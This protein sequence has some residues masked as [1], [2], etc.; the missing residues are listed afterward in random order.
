MKLYKITGGKMKRLILPFMIL[1]ILLLNIQAYASKSADVS[2]SEVKRDF[3]ET[4]DLWRSSD[5]SSL[6]G[7]VAA[8]GH[9]TE[10]GFTAR[11]KSA[12]LKPSCCWEKLQNVSVSV[13][14]EKKAILK[15]KVGLDGNGGTEYK[16]KAFKLTKEDGVW[17]ISKSD[18]YA[19]AEAKKKGSRK[20][21]KVKRL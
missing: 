20:R 9:D 19:L 6:Y 15:G 4:L 7:R 10:E 12:P 16:T 13:Q 14:S 3:E 5:Y 8:I 11:M 1:F 17:K 21:G 18:L 2:E